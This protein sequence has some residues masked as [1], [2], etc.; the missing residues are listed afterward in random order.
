[1]IRT[2]QIGPII[3][4]K[5]EQNLRQYAPPIYWYLSI[6]LYSM[7]SQQAVIFMLAAVWTSDLI[8]DIHYFINMLC[9]CKFLISQ[10]W[11]AWTKHFCI[12]DIIE[13]LKERNKVKV[14][15]SR[16]RP[17][18]ALRFPG[19]WGSQ[20][21][22]HQHMEVARLSALRTGRLYPPGNIPGTHFF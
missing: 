20:I 15:Q 8:Y 1:M 14:K 22:R 19:G 10:S 17:G 13:L 16:Y 12:K 11:C 6:K 4:K 9:R 3:L 5:S 21:S 18:E 7:M 2:K